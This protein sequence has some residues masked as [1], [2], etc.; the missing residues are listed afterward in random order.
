[1]LRFHLCLY[2]LLALCATLPCTART[3]AEHQQQPVNISLGKPVTLAPLPNRLTSAKKAAAKA[4]ALTDGKR[5]AARSSFI[6]EDPQV[7]S[8]KYAGQVNISIDLGEVFL[9]D[10][11]AANLLGGSEPHPGGQ[12]KS[13][14]TRVELLVSNDA[15]VYYRLDSF[16]HWDKADIERFAVPEERG[17][18]WTHELV[19]T[20]LNIRARWVGLRIYSSGV[21]ATDEITVTG[22]PLL[23][24]SSASTTV[25]EPF[26]GKAPD[27][28]SVKSPD[29]HFHRQRLQIATNA[30]LPA[31][32]GVV[33]PASYP[34]R[35]GIE[36]VMELPAGVTL[37]GGNFGA[38]QVA[39]VQGEPIANGGTRYTLPSG[40][41]NPAIR[42]FRAYGRLQL[43]ASGLQDGDSGQIDYYYTDAQ[44]RRSP[45]LSIPFDVATV[46]P[47]PQL[48]RLMLGLGWWYPQHS[49]QWPDMIDSLQ[50]IGLNTFPYTIGNSTVIKAGNPDIVQVEQARAKGFKIALIDSTI[51][52]MHLRNR[53]QPEIYTE[54]T[55][56]SRGKA[57]S[58]VYRGRLWQEEVERFAEAMAVLRPDF[59]AQ[60]IELWPSSLRKEFDFRKKRTPRQEADTGDEIQD[61]MDFA[62]AASGTGLDIHSEADFRA[63]GLSPALWQQSK[64]LEMWET[65]LTAARAKAKAN[66]HSLEGLS[67]GGYNFRPRHTYQGFFNFNTLQ[68]KNLITHS[69][70]SYY[71][72]YYPSQIAQLGDTIR[73]D[74]QDLLSGIKVMPWLTPGDAGPYPP[75]AFQ[76][77]LLEAFANGAQG[78]WFWS[79]RLWDAQTLIAYNGVI[80]AIAPFEDVIADG[81][82]AQ[83]LA[84]LHGAGRLS[85]LQSGNRALLLLADY[86][87]ENKGAPLTLKLNLTEPAT[88]VDLFSGE[89]LA[90]YLSQ[91]EHTLQIPLNG[92][93]SRLIG[94][95]PPAPVPAGTAAGTAA[96]TVR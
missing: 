49:L 72:T 47:A 4:I 63:S 46:T 51:T 36:L 55:D 21:T 6:W 27:S 50:T 23:P 33:F 76:A 87:D 11:V 13:F 78:I 57:V 54:F 68:E 74:R 64:G 20:D 95:S 94:L 18:A 45:R 30:T 77:L 80:R 9:I 65:L 28:F 53:N 8:W 60:D 31:P 86:E 81:H 10:S 22:T 48:E 38:L 1:M 52:R 93:L 41:R 19:F 69:Q 75:E 89:V 79:N 44:G 92:K 29:L 35:E 67:N 70:P 58:P 91:A 71:S 17:K 15:E 7:P 96:N 88:L 26:T 85:A 2:T 43:R 73:T 61:H 34:A 24:Q 3:Q 66:G 56:G 59:L 32:V 16:S 62:N 90:E 37:E 25:A 12:A 39:T 83:D 82:P 5:S 40:K 42:D 14:P 84:S